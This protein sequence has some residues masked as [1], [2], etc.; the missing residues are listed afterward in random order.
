MRSALPL[1]RLNAPDDLIILGQ[2]VS[3]SR[4][5]EFCA[6]RSYRLAW[7]DDHVGL[8][9]KAAIVVAALISADDEGLEPADYHIREI[10]AL[11]AATTDSARTERDFLITDGLLRYAEDVGNGK[12]SRSQTDERTIGTQ[13]NGM[14]AY[15]E[16]V[17][18]FDADALKLALGLLPPRNAEY[19]VLKATLPDLRR[20]VEVGG[21]QA[22]PDG[23]TI[24]PGSRDPVVQ[25]LRKRL[26]AEGWIQVSAS[27]ATSGS[28]DLYDPKLEA[29][30]TAFQARHGIKPDG[31]L[32]KDTR[33]ALNLPAEPRLR[34][35][36]VNMERARWNRLPRGGRTIEINLAAY[37][38][39][40][41]QDGESVLSM[42]VVVGTSENPTPIISSRITTVVLNPDWTLPPNVIREILPRIRHD[43][44]YLSS[45]GIE[46]IE[47]DGQVRFVQPPG[48]TN[49]LGRY[50]L[51]MPNDQDIYLHDTPDSAKFRYALRGFSHGCVRLKDA[52]ALAALLLEDRIQTMPDGPSGL[53]EKGETRHIALSKPVPVSLVYRTA[54]LDRDGRL[55]LGGDAYGRDERLWKAMHKLRKSLPKRLAVSLVVSGL[56]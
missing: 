7:D 2:P 54:W 18:S 27:P 4:L 26:I 12:L 25:D 38:L 10:I 40:V 56:L 22:L 43:A 19:R 20:M 49:P 31:V 35:M 45:R 48:P 9:P 24:H 29:A 39:N 5:H 11:A 15:L 17:A 8:G 13:S 6:T 16:F 53:L 30:V 46:R 42:P 55:V 14:V 1:L 50:K 37:S 28:D 3:T 51:I 34:Q 21:W 33:A 23:E 36:I 32:G 52:A 44:D 47:E 41:Y